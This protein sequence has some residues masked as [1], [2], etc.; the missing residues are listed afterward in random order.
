[1]TINEQLN[2]MNQ[3]FTKTR[4]NLIPTQETTETIDIKV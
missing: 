4:T 2:G 1:M 3:E